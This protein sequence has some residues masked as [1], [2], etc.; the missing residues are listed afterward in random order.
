M[1]FKIVTGANDSY[2]LTLLNFINYNSNIG[3]NLENIIIYDLGLNKTNLQK[4]K[5]ILDGKTE[6]KKLN[7]EEY[8][9]HVDLDKY[10]GLNCS[11]AFKAIIIYN[12][13]I[14][15]NNNPIIWLDCAC[16][17][18]IDMLNKIRTSIKLYGFYCPIGNNE[19]TIESI[20][21]NHPQTLNLLGITKQQ[22]INE[23]QTRLACICGVIYNNFNGKTILDDWYKYSLEKNVIMPV[24]S[25]RNNH[26]Q[27][28]TVLSGIMFL[29]EKNNNIVFEKS[30]FNISCW[31]KFDESNVDT[32][33]NKYILFQRNNNQ[34]LACIYTNTLEDAIQIYYERKQITKMLFNKMLF[35]TY[36]YVLKE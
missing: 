21:L 24:G 31:N 7:Y 11:Y 3:I 30:N 29:Y 25:S 8:P 10:N 20:E 19:T 1:D 9:E 6:I 14:I 13:A 4:L 27:D 26:R 33:Y 15:Y 12:E 16:R 35:N 36:F 17:A 28:Q 2:I 18:T 22:H 34:Q 5:S 23:L 32:N